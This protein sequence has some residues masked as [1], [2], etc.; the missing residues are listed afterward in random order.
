[1]LRP[2]RRPHRPSLAR[3]RPHLVL[4]AAALIV[5]SG[6]LLLPAAVATPDK[7]T[8]TSGARLGIFSA[9]ED[10]GQVAKKGSVT[11]D[12]DKGIYRVTGGGANMWAAQDAFHFVWTKA[13]GDLGLV[14][15]IK[16]IG[17]SAQAHR[18]AC[19]ILR[20]SLDADAPYVDAVLH[21]DGLASL[22]YREVRGGPTREI[23]SNVGGPATLA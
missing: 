5:A 11:F 9:S 14:A 16:W 23:Q 13:S 2:M 6:W 3:R 20:Q 8:K 1:M 19:L 18:K 12:A 15:G 22:Q 7:K 21:G 17:T 10:V 4:Y